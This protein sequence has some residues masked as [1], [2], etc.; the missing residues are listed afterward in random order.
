MR[1]CL[2]LL[3]FVA[4]AAHPRAG[5]AKTVYRVETVAGSSNP[6]DG[7]P[8][9]AA[10]IGEMQGLAVDRFGNLYLSD[11]DN[12]RVRKVGSNG[13]ITNLAGTGTAGF[14]GDG[15]PAASAS[16]NLPYGL[17]VDLNGNLFIADLGNLRVRRISPDGTITTV[18]GN[19]QKGSAGD[20]GPA[21]NAQLMTP[22]NLAVDAAGNLYIAEFEG[23]RVRKMSPDGKIA[24]MAGSG[25]LGFRGDG[26]PATAAQ[27]GYP[28]GLAVDRAGALYI[29]DSQNQRIRKVLPGGTIATVLGG[30]SATALQTPTALAVD[31][32]G[33]IYVA[34]R[35]NVVRSYT[36]AGAWINVAGTGNPGFAGDGGPAAAAQLTA[37]HDLAVDVYGILYIAD[38][39]NHRVRKVVLG[40]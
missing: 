33:T 40:K 34:D 32:A 4:C 11:T 18:A 26:G 17:A 24:T 37:A 8:A 25:V 15:G 14:A 35:S 13:V 22:R 2:F 6:G 39:N 16:L 29:A 38:S 30:T 7:G 27:L 21:T 23:H 10:Q 12:H 9:V 19:G 31:T 1:N 5:V 3:L 36:S 20:G 28:A